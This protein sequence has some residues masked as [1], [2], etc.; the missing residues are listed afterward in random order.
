M[1]CTEQRTFLKV[2]TAK[3]LEAVSYQYEEL[4]GR[5]HTLLDLAQPG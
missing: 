2:E 1:I 3:N 5:A 4:T